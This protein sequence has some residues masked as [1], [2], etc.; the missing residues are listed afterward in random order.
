MLVDNRLTSSIR[1]GTVLGV[2]MTRYAYDTNSYRC[3]DYENSN[4]FLLVE[5]QDKDEWGIISSVLVSYI[6]NFIDLA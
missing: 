1:N 4:Y 3:K 2:G 6:R 5:S